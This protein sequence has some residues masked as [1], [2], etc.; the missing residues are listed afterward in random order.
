MRIRKKH[1]H[2]TA[3]CDPRRAKEK[4]SLRKERKAEPG[5]HL[6]KKQKNDE[7]NKTDM[8]TRNGQEMRSS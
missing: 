5:K 6:S 3:G 8:Q 1:N 4:A 2:R 7:R